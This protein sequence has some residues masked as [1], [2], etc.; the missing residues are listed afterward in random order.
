MMY[1]GATEDLSSK[2]ALFYPP[3]DRVFK[4][5]NPRLMKGLLDEDD[6]DN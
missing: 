3:P 1:I 5:K 6:D 2:D 4:F